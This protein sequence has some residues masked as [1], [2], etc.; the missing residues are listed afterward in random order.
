MLD[1]KKLAVI[2]I[3]KKEL[4]LADDEY[5]AMLERTAGVRS[6]RDLD[7]TGFRKLMRAFV[8]SRHYVLRPGGLTLRQKLFI[9]DLKK[10]L[11]WADEHFRNFLHKY[12]QQ[13][14]VRLLTRQD[15][16]KVIESLKNVLR[17]A[18]R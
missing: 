10:R 12:Y 11:G 15:A 8:K 6:S 1:R 5:R 16:I 9:D 13:T 17:H 14:D 4:E 7:D 2:H 3:I 18:D